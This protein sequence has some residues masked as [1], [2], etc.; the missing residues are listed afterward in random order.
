MKS[1]QWTRF[2][3]FLRS[4][5]AQIWLQYGASEL[6]GALGCYL[7]S[8]DDTSLPMGNPLPDVQCLLIDEQGHVISSTDDGN[9]LGEIHIG[10]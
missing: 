2:L 8:M 1:Q 9:V 6:N 7:T 5:K 3:T 10:G 4:S